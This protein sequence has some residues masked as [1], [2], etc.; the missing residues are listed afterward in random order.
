MMPCFQVD[1]MGEACHLR[2]NLVRGEALVSDGW[3]GGTRSGQSGAV[4]V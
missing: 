3:A 2:E 4:A 1:R